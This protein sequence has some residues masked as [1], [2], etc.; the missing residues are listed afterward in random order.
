M[1][2]AP[3]LLAW[4]VLLVAWAGRVTG[5]RTIGGAFRGGRFGPRPAAVLHRGAGGRRDGAAHRDRDRGGQPPL[6]GADSEVR[7]VIGEVFLTNFAVW[8][9]DRYIRSGGE[10]IQDRIPAL[11]GQHPERLRWDDNMFSTNMFAHPYHGNLYF[12]AARSSGYSYWQSIPYA[13]GGSFMWEYF[14]ET[15]NPPG[16]T[17]SRPASAARPW[18]RR[19]SACRRSSRTTPRPARRERGASW[20]ARWSIPCAAS[21]GLFPAIGPRFRRTRRIATPRAT[22][23]A[24]ASGSAPWARITSGTP[25]PRASSWTWRRATAIPSRASTRSRS[26]PSTTASS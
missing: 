10:R 12:N 19:F 6:H 8:F 25:T 2:A 26:T 13:F 17:G 16:T 3:I 15:H 22:A 9:Y 5:I 21:T 4:L 14:G 7:P 24:T 11:E 1:R 23:W 18:A 20:A